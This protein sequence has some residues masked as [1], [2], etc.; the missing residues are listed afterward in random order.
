MKKQK[1]SQK[2][3]AGKSES[4]YSKTELICYDT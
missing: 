4:K 3:F 2:Y 1:P